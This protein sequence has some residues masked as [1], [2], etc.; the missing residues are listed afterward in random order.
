MRSRVGFVRCHP[1]QLSRPLPAVTYDPRLVPVAP[2]QGAPRSIAMTPFWIGSSPDSA[3]PLQL[4][5]VAPRHV[6]LMER[7]DGFYLAPVSGRAPRAAA[8]RPP[9]SGPTRMEN[10]DTVQIVPGVVWRLETGEPLPVEEEPEEDVFEGVARR[11][12]KKKKKR[13]AWRGGGHGR[14]IAVWTAV[15][16]VVALLVVAGIVVYNGAT[17]RIAGDAPFRQRR[18]ALRLAATRELRSHGARLDAARSRAQ[19]PGAAGVRALDERR[20]RRAGCATIR[21]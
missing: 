11:S 16:A 17:K 8:Q 1:T 9:R 5:G 12:G 6:A 19:R 4:P 10:G 3:L 18:V 14:T 21:G 2:T 20:S 13:R 15:L 7:E